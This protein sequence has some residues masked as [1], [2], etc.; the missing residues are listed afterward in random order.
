VNR[1]LIRAVRAGADVFYYHPVYNWRTHTNG[2]LVFD[3]RGADLAQVDRQMVEDR[4]PTTRYQIEAEE[5][6]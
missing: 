4:W 6:P 1:Y 5:V 2:A 3:K